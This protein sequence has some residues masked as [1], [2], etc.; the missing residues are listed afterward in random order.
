M[1]RYMYL[2]VHHTHFYNWSAPS[3]YSSTAA[4]DDCYSQ[5]MPY[6]ALTHSY[7]VSFHDA[8]QCLSYAH[9]QHQLQLPYKSCRTCLTKHVSTWCRIMPLVINS[10]RNGHTTQTHTHTDVRTETMLRNWVGASLCLACAWFER[11]FG[12][13][14]SCSAEFLLQSTL[15]ESK[16]LMCRGIGIGL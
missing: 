15:F 3:C 13:L 2:N 10:L 11:E 16:E 14:V 12:E 9:Y 5:L 1:I 4:F 6:T 7:W 8:Y